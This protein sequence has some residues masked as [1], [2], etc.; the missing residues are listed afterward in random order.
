MLASSS[1]SLSLSLPPALPLQIPCFPRCHAVCWPAA[2]RAGPGGA[3]HLREGALQVPGRR[4]E[5]AEGMVA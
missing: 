3:G 1:L 2:A 4:K 5:A